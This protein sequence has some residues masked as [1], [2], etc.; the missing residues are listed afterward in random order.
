MTKKQQNKN[1]GE[2]RIQSLKQ[3]DFY[4]DLLK[5]LPDIELIDLKKNND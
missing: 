2:K 3:T 4:K 5:N 1:F